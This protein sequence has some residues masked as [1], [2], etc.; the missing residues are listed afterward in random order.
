VVA[1]AGPLEAGRCPG[2]WHGDP[3]QRRAAGAAGVGQGPA[4]RCS[5]RPRLLSESAQGSRVSAG[6]VAIAAD[7]EQSRRGRARGLLHAAQGDTARC[8]QPKGMIKSTASLLPPRT[9]K[10]PTSRPRG[11]SMSGKRGATLMASRPPS[12]E[13]SQAPVPRKG[14]VGR[15]S[16]QCLNPHDLG[17]TP[18]Q[19]SP[20]RRGRKRSISRS[21]AMICG[22][23]LLLAM[24]TVVG[25]NPISR[26]RKTLRLAG[27][28]RDCSPLESSR[29]QSSAA[30]LMAAIG[31]R[32]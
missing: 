25:S 12:G 26:S 10:T 19:A 31:F 27:H 17:A 30:G 15:V 11:L 22:P 14:A 20:A 13:W 9:A 21:F 1:G 3:G 8:R 23:Q 4:L 5:P 16:V 24:Q 7:Q 29:Q 28:E 18:G 2:P 32:P 6:A